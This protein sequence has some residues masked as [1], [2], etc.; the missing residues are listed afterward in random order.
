MNITEKIQG[1][2]VMAGK[3]NIT[4]NYAST[5]N[6]WTKKFDVDLMFNVTVVEAFTS[7]LITLIK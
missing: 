1:G 5:N 6:S 7:K 3:H 2:S 4:Q